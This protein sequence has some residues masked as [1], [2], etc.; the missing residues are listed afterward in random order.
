MP[1]RSAAAKVVR[2]AA[3]DVPAAAAAD[4]SRLRDA[5]AGPISTSDIAERRGSFA[6]LQRDASGRLPRRAVGK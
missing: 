3:A 6:R 1:K 4:L 5:M 2:R